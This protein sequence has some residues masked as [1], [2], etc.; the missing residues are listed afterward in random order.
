[1]AQRGTW[2]AAYN[3]YE[4]DASISLFLLVASLAVF[5][6]PS[7]GTA[8]AP[9]GR[10]PALLSAAAAGESCAH[11]GQLRRD[12]RADRQARRS[13]SERRRPSARARRLRADATRRPRRRSRRRVGR[14]PASEAALELG[15]LQHMLGTPD[16]TAILERVAPQAETSDDPDELARAARALRALGRFQEANAAYRDASTGAPER[17]RRSRPAGASC[18]SRSTTTPKR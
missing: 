3:K 2:V 4:R 1:M 15:L 13:R 16:A 12:R 6:L 11:R 5:A 7:F 9:R 14:A 8:Q 18:F 10:S 17:S